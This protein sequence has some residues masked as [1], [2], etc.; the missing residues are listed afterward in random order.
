MSMTLAAV[1]AR[2]QAEIGEM[3]SKHG[4]LGAVQLDQK[5][6]NAYLAMQSWMPPPH[7]YVTSAFT[8]AAGLDTFTLPTAAQSGYVSLS[9]YAGDVRIRLTNR[10]VYGM[11][12]KRK[13]E[14]IEAMRNVL[15]PAH[16][17]WP[18]DYCL[19]EEVDQKVKG[20]CWPQATID[21]PCDL[22]VSLVADDLR[23][24][25][26]MAAANIRFSRYGVTALIYRA[27]AL[28]VQAMSAETLTRNNLN[29]NIVREW[30][31]MSDRAAWKDQARLHNEQS[32]G[33]V[34]RNVS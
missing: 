3:D 2:V 5:I 30:M 25:T 31:A 26:D 16:Q 10:P 29:P 23:D 4:S 32:V 17:G 20:R 13:V 15:L 34:L 22:F 21:E 6:A 27:A 9:Q 7:L 19:W 18:R 24:A 1:R 12:N 11:L 14:E 28:C 8:I 33:R